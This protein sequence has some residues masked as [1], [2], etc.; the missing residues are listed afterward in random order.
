MVIKNVCQGNNIVLVAACR[1]YN[2]GIGIHLLQID[3]K[4]LGSVPPVKKEIN[5]R[6]DHISFQVHFTFCTCQE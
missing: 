5:P 6:D 1:L 4:E 3:N 2:Y